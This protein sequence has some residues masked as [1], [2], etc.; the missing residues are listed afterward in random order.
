MASQKTI[1]VLNKCGVNAKVWADRQNNYAT[2]LLIFI[3]ESI[4]FR[5]C[6]VTIMERKLFPT[7][8]FYDLRMGSLEY[9]KNINLLL[10]DY[11]IIVICY[12]QNG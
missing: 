1:N 7:I 4:G 9:L 2:T 11:L 3:T 12:P 5:M 8:D 6:L 10:F